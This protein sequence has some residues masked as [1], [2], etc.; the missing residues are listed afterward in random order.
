MQQ[1]PTQSRNKKG[2]LPDSIDY[3]SQSSDSVSSGTENEYKKNEQ[4]T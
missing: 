4:E 2:N 1:N 3:V